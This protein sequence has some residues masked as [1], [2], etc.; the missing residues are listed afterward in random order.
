M[1]GLVPGIDDLT[2]TAYGNPGMPGPKPGMTRQVLVL[3]SRP[4][5]GGGNFSKAGT[6]SG[7]WWNGCASDV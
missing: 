6:P 5:R 7:N 1:A 4:H 3:Q 2:T